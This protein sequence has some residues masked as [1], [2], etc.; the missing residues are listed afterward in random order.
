MPCFIKGYHVY[1]NVRLPVLDEELYEKM[2]PSNSADK[3]AVAVRKKIVKMVNLRKLFSTSVGLTHMENAKYSWLKKLLIKAMVKGC[4]CLVYFDWLGKHTRRRAT[5]KKLPRQNPLRQKP[6][7][8][9]DKIS[10]QNL[11]NPTLTLWGVLSSQFWGLL[12]VHD[13]GDIIATDKQWKYQCS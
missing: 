1:R 10:R 7:N 13:G 12:S 2:D 11:P 8:W 5:W 6:P 4:R 3:C 9:V